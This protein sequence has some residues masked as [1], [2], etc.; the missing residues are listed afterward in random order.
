LTPAFERSVFINCPFDDDYAPILQAIAFCICDLGFV[1]RIAPEVADNAANRLDRV[2][3]LIRGSKYGIHDLSRCKSSSANEFSRMNM[4]FELGLDHGSR[5][6]GDA[7][8]KLKTILILEHAR[9][10]YQKALSD[11]AGWDIQHHGGD[12]IAAVRTVSLWL[13]RQANA[14]KI[15]ASRILGN[16]ATFQEWYWEREL[17]AGSSEDDITAYPTIQMVE[18]MSEWVAAGRP[19]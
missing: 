7:N 5:R 19:V 11:I 12:H 10:D 16:Y 3:D 14:E 2:I 1:P 9:Y 13:H 15:G 8:L 18:A 17:A 4:P 6:Y